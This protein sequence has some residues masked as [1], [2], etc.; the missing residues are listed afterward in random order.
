MKFHIETPSLILREFRE[1]DVDAMFAMD[2][3]PRVHEFLG[4]QPETSKA[5]A[6]ELIQYVISQYDIF[7]IGRW[8]VIEKKSNEVIG[9]AGLKFIAE[10]IMNY[11]PYY[12]VGY[13]LSPEFWNRGY[14]TE[15]CKASIRYGFEVLKLQQIIGTCHH[16]NKA[17]R[18]VLE[19]CGLTFSHQ[20]YWKE[21]LCDWLTIENK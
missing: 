8:A 4:N 19:K 20:V 9:W 13:R 12:D 1:S 14:A 16:Q 18:R 15:A 7:G 3:N 2:A 17:S 21:I 11:T 6:L 10:P 5:H